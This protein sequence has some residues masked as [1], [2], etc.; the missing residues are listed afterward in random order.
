MLVIFLENPQPYLDSATSMQKLGF[1][2]NAKL[3]GSPW[4]IT[5]ATL[6]TNF[7]ELLNTCQQALKQYKNKINTVS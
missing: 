6:K 1:S 3:V 7:D 4:V 2:G 5:A